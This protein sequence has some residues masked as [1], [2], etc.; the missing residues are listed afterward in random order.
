[1]PVLKSILIRSFYAALITA[2]V[3]VQLCAQSAVSREYQIKA[4]FLFNFTQFVDW[5]AS[6]FSA[7]D[8]P[9]VIAVL[10]ENPFG[11]YLKETVSGEKVKGHPVVVQYYDHPEEIKTCHILFIGLSDPKKTEQVIS[12]LKEKSILT[13]SDMTGFLQEGGMIKFFTRQNNIRFEINP[14]AAKAADLT[15]SSKLLRVAEIFDPS[16]NK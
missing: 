10:G 6:S 13:I 8:A 14:A 3:S 2:C 1:M 11:S 15:V 9:I 16:K 5:P 7:D 12:A 4:A